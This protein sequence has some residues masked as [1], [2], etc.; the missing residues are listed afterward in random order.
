MLKYGM[1]IKVGAFALLTLVVIVWATVKVSDRGVLVRGSYELNIELSDATGLKKKAPVLLSGV[2]VGIVDGVTLSGDNRAIVRLLVGKDLHLPSDSKALL[3]TRGFLGETY[4]ELVPGSS[5][6]MLE[7]GGTV[8]FA[9]RTGD[10]NSL[11]SD[12][13]GIAEDIKAITSSLRTVMGDSENSTVNKMLKNWEALSST[14]NGLASR[15]EQNIDRITSNMADFTAQLKELI[16]KSKQQVTDSM[17]H[18]SSIAAKIDRGEGTV[19]RLINDDETVQNLNNTLESL[20]DTLGGFRQLETELGYHTE[21]LGK[22]HDFKHYVSLALRP[23]P[24]KAFMLDLVADPAPTPTHVLRT[25]A[26]TVNNVTSTVSTD[27]STID[28]GKLRFSAQLAKKFYD[29]TLRGGI[30]E[31]TG[32]LGLDYAIGPL[33]LSFSAYDFST[34]YGERPH[35]KASGGVNLTRNF[36][37]MGGGD[38]LI[39]PSGNKDWFVGAGFKFVDDDL[40]MLSKFGGTSSLGK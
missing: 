5:E 40:K 9:K 8:G 28:R 22:S 21:Y 24:D 19:G 23:A 1:E 25:T 27:T 3:K 2:E 32:G 34:R 31:S 17:D 33:D 15:N 36:F 26:V 39:S 10:I 37:I 30:I 35:L 7:K 29:L 12:F 16:G 13:S 4:V 11:V 14:L 20:Q 38:D 6:E 18:I